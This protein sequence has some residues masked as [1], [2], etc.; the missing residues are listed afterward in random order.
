MGQNHAYTMVAMCSTGVLRLGPSEYLLYKNKDFGRSSFDD[1]LV[2]EPA[3]FGIRGITTWAGDDPEH[4]RFSGFS[5][6][7]NQ[8]G[9][10][11][12]DSNVATL[13]DHENYDDL[14][15]IA[16]REGH[17]VDSGIEAIRRATAAR[18]YLWAN[19]L[20]IDDHRLAALEV[21]GHA[22]EVTHAKDRIARSNHHVTL[23]AQPTDDDSVTSSRRLESADARLA[24]ARSIDDIFALQASHRHG[25]TGVCNHSIYDTV[26]AY[27]LHRHGD[28]TTLFVTQGHPCGNAERYVLT[29]PLGSM[30]SRT[31]NNGF[32]ASYPST[33]PGAAIS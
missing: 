31:T 16:L 13:P 20:L 5:I 7:T 28:Q 1:R 17:D 3:V 33:R 19:I 24:T 12:C 29:V 11:G 26:Y 27:V 9:L 25:G 30:S 14:V 6:G 10:F 4:D 15:E 22:I 18:P 8:H 2:L 32:R 23:G 21:R